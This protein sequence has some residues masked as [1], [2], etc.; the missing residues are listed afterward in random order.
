M[1]PYTSRTK[2][3]HNPKYYGGQM[4][5][6]ADHWSLV[7]MCGPF[8]AHMYRVWEG[9]YIKVCKDT[10]AQC[11]KYMPLTEPYGPSNE[12][13]MILEPMKDSHVNHPNMCK[14]CIK[15]YQD[16][17]LI[18]SKHIIHPNNKEKAQ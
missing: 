14:H 7:E 13:G 12:V 6:F 15:R 1:G 5:I 4:F 3:T 8:K 18:R 11:D 17:L 2:N 10:I 9:T 16:W